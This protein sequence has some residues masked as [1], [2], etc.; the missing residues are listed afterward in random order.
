MNNPTVPR[1]PRSGLR[2]RGERQGGA[3]VRRAHGRVVNNQYG[4][5]NIVTTGGGAAKSVYC[6]AKSGTRGNKG[7]WIFKGK[8]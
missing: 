7:W 5:R 3:G 2:P 8:F 4:M 1:K 6:R